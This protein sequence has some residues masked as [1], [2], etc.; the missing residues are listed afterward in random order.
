MMIFEAGMHVNFEKVRL[1][2]AKACCVA[3]IGTFMPIILGALIIGLMGYDYY[4]NGLAVGISL[5]PTSIGISLKLLGEM[6]VLDRLFGQS[7]IVAA[8]VDDILALIAF[9]LFFAVAA[10]NSG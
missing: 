9:Q 10:P 3:V 2:G 7:I 8:V 1:V 6:G 4:P 5:S